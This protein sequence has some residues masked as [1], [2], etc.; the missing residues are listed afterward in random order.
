MRGRRTEGATLSRCHPP[1]VRVLDLSRAIAG[2]L[3]CRLLGD[4][5]ADVMEGTQGGAAA[6]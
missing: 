5:D 4:V 6:S 3:C 2:P 1:H